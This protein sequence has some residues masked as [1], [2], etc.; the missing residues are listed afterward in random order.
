MSTVAEFVTQGL[1][2]ATIT[3][4]RRLQDALWAAIDQSAD[5]KIPT[6]VVVGQLEF[7]KAAMIH[8]R[9]QEY[10]QGIDK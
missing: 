4:M 2:P 6:A 7:I 5:D 3:A 9:F 1:P 10:L 8:D